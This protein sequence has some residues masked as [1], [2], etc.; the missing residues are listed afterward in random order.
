MNTVREA[1]TLEPN[2][3]EANLFMGFYLQFA[4]K[5]ELAVKHLLV[6]GR[7]SPVATYRDVAFLAYAH[8]MNHNYTEVVR[9]WKESSLKPRGTMNIAIASAYALLDRPQEAAA[10]VKNLL[11]DRPG[12]NMSQWKFINSWKLQENR[13]RLYNAAKKAGIP[14]FPNNT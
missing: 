9:I 14:E 13:T 6:A 1:L 2:G 3:Y 12:F 7:L 11:K 8:F 4:G 10:V 5:A